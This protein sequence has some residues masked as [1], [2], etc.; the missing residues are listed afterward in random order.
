MSVA[1]K[2]LVSACL[3]GRPVRYDGKASR[4]HALLERLQA[5]GRVVSVCPEVS[6]GLAVPRPAAEIVGGDGL[7]V[8]SGR[9][10]VMTADTID[11]TQAFLDGAH[12][13]LAL[14]KSQNVVAVVLKARSPSCGS[15]QI[16]DGSHSGT[17]VDGLGITAALL[18]REGFLVYSEDDLD[19]LTLADFDAL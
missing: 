14:A 5:D 18:R 9:A 16:Y 2:I 3:L 19:G 13:A 4:G 11:V 10:R 12:H 15:L 8:L 17:L 7:D 1:S 6:G